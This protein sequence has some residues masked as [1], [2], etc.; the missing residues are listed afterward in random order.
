MGDSEAVKA[1][2]FHAGKTCPACQKEI[3][4][5]ES[6]HL[7]S[8]CG[9]A[10]HEL[11]WRRESG[12]KSYFCS[13]D[14]KGEAGSGAIITISKDEA[15]SLPAAKLLPATSLYPP[16]REG[17]YKKRFSKLAILALLLT[18]LSAGIL[19][20]ITLFMAAI[21]LGLIINNSML[22][23]R[24]LAIVSMLLSI[25]LLVCWV[26][27][28]YFFFRG[29]MGQRGGP[30]FSESP[31]ALN[32]VAE[33]IRGSMRANVVVRATG[34]GLGG[35]TMMGSGVIVSLNKERALILTNRHVID[36]G[37]RNGDTGAPSAAGIEVF[38]CGKERVSAQVEWSHPDGVDL[39]LLKC[40]PEDIASPVA[41][42]IEVSPE[43]GIGADVFAVGN[44][45]ELGW[46]YTRG[47]ISN[48]RESLV[49]RVRFK[50]YQTQTPINQGNSGGGLY[51]AAGVLVGINTWTQSKNVSEGLSF[52]I[53]IE[54]AKEVLSSLVKEATGKIPAE[55]VPTEEAK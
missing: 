47:V 46:T 41:A 38:F 11:C 30:E 28:G 1:S 43:I 52:A 32:N 15:E 27:S 44:P 10:S 33:P 54:A 19:A 42:R 16:G 13:G 5:G 48:V 18:V 51:S 50:V 6:I 21:A 31:E 7:C 20:P 29:K 35:G 34:R 14:V 17:R 8:S 40:Q 45:M 39:V 55:P 37:Y 36:P 12:C 26:T 49:G 2:D 4:S 25:V 53:A 24:W 22:R 9:G 3:R 23:G